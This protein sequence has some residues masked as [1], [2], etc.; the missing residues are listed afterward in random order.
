MSDDWPDYL[1]DPVGHCEAAFK[2]G[3]ASARFNAA[4]ILR[5]LAADA[6]SAIP[7][8]VQVMRNDI[9]DQVRAQCAFAMIDI[10]YSVKERAKVAVTALIETLHD[11]FPEARSLAASALA[12]IGP[13]AKVAIPALRDA[14]RDDHEC[15]RDAAQKALDELDSRGGAAEHQDEPSR[16]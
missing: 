7:A 10:G 8:I 9:D 6:E 15:V 4:D 2:F 3:D 16:H 1:E 13:T 14:L 11:S 5:G 12:A